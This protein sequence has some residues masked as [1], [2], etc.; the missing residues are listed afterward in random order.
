MNDQSMQGGNVGV[1]AVMTERVGKVSGSSSHLLDGDP[2]QEDPRYRGHA[3]PTLLHEGWRVKLGIP[4]SGGVYL[5]LEGRPPPTARASA[6][7][8]AQAAAGGGAPVGQPI[9][10]PVR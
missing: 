6:A 10:S 7:T 5:V 1:G 4:F 2:Y 9:G 3:L 8:D